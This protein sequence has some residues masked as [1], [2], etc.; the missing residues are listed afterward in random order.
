MEQ[1]FYYEMIYILIFLEF[2]FFKKNIIFQYRI[3]LV[4]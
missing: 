3:D 4:I 2:D 1:F